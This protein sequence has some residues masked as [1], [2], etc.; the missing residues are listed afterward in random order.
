MNRL[1]SPNG[2]FGVIILIS[3]LV[4]IHACTTPAPVNDNK[5]DSSAAFDE[6]PVMQYFVNPEYPESA[7]Q[8]GLEGI[9]KI[10]CTVDETGRVVEAELFESNVSEE[11]DLAALGAARSCRFKPARKNGKPVR[12]TVMVPFQFALSR[13]K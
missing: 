4:L 6:P 2:F 10:K 8:S 11:M 3:M 5:S 7:V 1:K 13:D 9:I 12:S